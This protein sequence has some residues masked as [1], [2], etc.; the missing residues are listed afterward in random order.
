MLIGVR[1]A[2]RAEI[3]AELAIERDLKVAA[4]LQDRR[5]ERG[6]RLAFKVQSL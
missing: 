5:A 2:C 3:C 1:H 6:S 4:L